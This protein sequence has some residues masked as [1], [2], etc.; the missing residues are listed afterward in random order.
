MNSIKSDYF[1]T[2][3]YKFLIVIYNI[4]LKG[5]YAKERRQKEKEKQNEEK[6]KK[7]KEK[8]RPRH[9]VLGLD[10]DPK[11]YSCLIRGTF[12]NMCMVKSVSIIM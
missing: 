9:Q 11:T 10:A 5:I 2:F 3:R 12:I 8:E 6:K 7:R 1:N 4:E